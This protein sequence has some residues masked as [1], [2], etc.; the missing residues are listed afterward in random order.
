MYIYIYK[1]CKCEQHVLYSSLIFLCVPFVVMKGAVNI[2]QNAGAISISESAF[3]GNSA[4]DTGG[5]SYVLMMMTTH[6]N[7]YMMRRRLIN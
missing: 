5:R 2:L 3:E 7:M 4:V 1:L 6:D